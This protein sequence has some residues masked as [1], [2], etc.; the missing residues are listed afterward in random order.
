MPQDAGEPQ[1]E[2]VHAT[3]R[4]AF[5]TT[6]DDLPPHVRFPR[7]EMSGLCARDECMGCDV[8]GCLFVLGLT[9]ASRSRRGCTPV[10]RLH[11]S[12]RRA[13][14]R[15]PLQWPHQVWLSMRMS[16]WLSLPV[17]QMW[18]PRSVSRVRRLIYRRPDHSRTPRRY[19]AFP[20]PGTAHSRRPQGDAA[21]RHRLSSVQ[22]RY[23]Q[24]T[25]LP[26]QIIHRL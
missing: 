3:V 6:I 9:R 24:R 19:S 13:G 8:A 23:K 22:A 11:K 10:T 12:L 4:S 21:R 18:T 15:R 5:R 25:L 7:K 26:N 17:Q 16:P 2:L 14:A 1:Q 20:S